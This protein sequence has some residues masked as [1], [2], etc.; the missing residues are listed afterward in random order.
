MG[1]SVCRK[2][3]PLCRDTSST[4]STVT[5]PTRAVTATYCFP[6]TDGSSLAGTWG[7]GDTGWHP[8]DTGW[9]PGDGDAPSSTLR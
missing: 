2:M 3:W 8:G 1:L 9:H 5:G 7:T 6:T 4:F